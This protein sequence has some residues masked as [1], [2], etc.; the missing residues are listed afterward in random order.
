MKYR[1]PFEKL[2]EIR[3]RTEELARRDHAS[4]A[5]AV[6]ESEAETGRMYAAIDR[7][8]ER[9]AEVERAGGTCAVALGQVD[10]FIRGQGTRI[11]RKRLQTRELKAVA[12]RLQAELVEA[13]RE[14]KTLEKLRE[15]RLIEHQTEAKKREARRLDELVITRFKRIES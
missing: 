10:D 9:A 14:R 5:A 4:A 15:R 3:K 8:R 13:A 11:E 7:A 6:T 1:F 2:L 12:E